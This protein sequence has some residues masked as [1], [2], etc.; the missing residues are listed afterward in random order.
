MTMREPVFGRVDDVNWVKD[1]EGLELEKVL[2]FLTNENTVSL[3]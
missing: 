3:T 1:M 2:Y